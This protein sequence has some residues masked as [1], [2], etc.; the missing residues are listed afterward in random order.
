[1]GKSFWCGTL[2]DVV[3]VGFCHM[4]FVATITRGAHPAASERRVVARVRTASITT[5][6]IEESR[7]W[8]QLCR[9]R[10]GEREEPRT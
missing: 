3:T 2:P 6:N 4:W 10:G 8:H 1:M 7:S 5:E 9:K